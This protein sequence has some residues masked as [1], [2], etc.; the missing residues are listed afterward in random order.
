MQSQTPAWERRI[1][2]QFGGHLSAYIARMGDIRNAV[3]ILW[4]ETACVT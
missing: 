4:D 2:F 1:H 3:I